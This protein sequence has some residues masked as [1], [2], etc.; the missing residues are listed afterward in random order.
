M[1]R[2]GFISKVA[3]TASIGSFL[4]S[5]SEEEMLSPVDKRAGMADSMTTNA[6]VGP[7][8]LRNR[9]KIPSVVSPAG[10]TLQSKPSVSD[11]GGG[12]ISRTW[13]YNDN[14]PGPTIK[15]MRGT[16]ANIQL[17]N[18][19]PEDTITHWHGMIVDHD[20]D[21]HPMHVISNGG[22]YQY[23]FNID[24]RATLNWYHPH[25]HMRTGAQVYYGQAGA[26]IINDDEELALGLPRD[27]FE[28]PLIIRD[29]TLDKTGNLHYR[30]RMGGFDGKIPL[31][32]GTINP[33]LTV[34]KAVYR[35]RILNGANARIFGLSLGNGASMKLIG[36]DGGLLPDLSE[37]TRIDFAPAERLDVL[38]DF[39]A[40][41]D[42]SKILL[43]DLRAGWDLL[44]FQVSG[45][46]VI[47]FTFPS[48]LPSIEYLAGPMTTRSFSF[49]AMSKI[50]GQEYSMERIDWQ[51]PLGQTELWRFTTTG[52]A[53]HP[54]HV[55]G[56][57]FQVISRTG[58]RNKLYPWEAGW[59][60]TV[61]LE[62]GET[63]EVLIRFDKFRGIYLM[64]C[65]KLEHED[66]GMMA[67]FEVI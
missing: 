56:A 22:S 47:P 44:E 2:R 66:M 15:A 53:P 23:N 48:T 27:E 55:H 1:K 11:L 7:A 67:N 51:V 29:A 65:H 21:G 45:T 34:K 14:F 30:P 36:N 31:V 16:T 13:T 58:G 6:R 18:F 12:Q 42:G 60:D 61:L 17:L 59:K 37:V 25:P 46:D 20:N 9:L 39:R 57:Y 28:V 43:R 41:N 33:F 19:L 62:D 35:F 64:H 3:V 32:N 52:N 5:C 8:P 54:V 38:I 49:D 63:V 24:Q 50:N 4:A 40:E 10:L 26:F